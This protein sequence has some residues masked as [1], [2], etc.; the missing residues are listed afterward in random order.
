MVSG[1]HTT[2]NTFGHAL[3]STNLVEHVGVRR[4]H[5]HP[6]GC[7]RKLVEVEPSA[8]HG[9]RYS[10]L[11]IRNLIPLV[12]F[13]CWVFIGQFFR[14]AYFFN[15]QKILHTS[16]AVWHADFGLFP[17]GKNSL[18]CNLVQLKNLVLLGFS[19]NYLVVAEILSGFLPVGGLAIGGQSTEDDTKGEEY[20]F[21]GQA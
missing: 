20:F 11:G 16:F 5:S 12:G 8:C 3:V 14:D 1:R 10:A 15:N 17:G 19:L 2:G 7:S 4:Q 6:L 21:H 18:K 13:D 9:E